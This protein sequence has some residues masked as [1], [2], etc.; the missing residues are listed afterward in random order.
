M[1]RLFGEDIEE[2]KIIEQNIKQ[3]LLFLN[4]T[5]GEYN[6]KFVKRKRKIDFYDLFFYM[7]H[8][9]SSI[10]ETHGSSNTNFCIENNIDV[11]ENAFINKLVKLDC[12]CIKNIN[13]RFINFYYTLF[14]ININDIVTAT[15][16]SNIKLLACTDKHFKLNSN[17]HYAN[18]SISCMYD[19]NNN[20][21]LSMNINNS[22][23]EID[24][25]L[26]QLQDNNI[27]KYKIT[28]VT[29]R[30]YDSDKLLKYYLE[31]NILFVS[32]ITKSNKYVNKLT[33][34]KSNEKFNVS[35]N[36]KIYN[37][38][39]IK[40]TNIEK[41]DIAETK[42]ELIIKMND[43][44]QKINLLKN[45]LINENNKYKKFHNENK[46]TNKE[47]RNIK[48]N[49][50]HINS[51]DKSKID[52]LSKKIKKTRISKNNCDDNIKKIKKDIDKFTKDKNLIKQKI[53]KLETYEHSDFYI[54]TNRNECSIEKLKKIYKQRWTVE[55]SFR[56]DKTVLNLNQMNNKNINLINQNVYIIQFI[57]IMNAFINKL[58][59]KKTK[60]D[61]YLNKTVIFKSLH[62]KI[63]S[64][65]KI[66]LR[67]KK[68]KS[69]NVAS[70]DINSIQKKKKHITNYEKLIHAL[71]IILKRQIKI[72]NDR[73]N[74]RIK[75][76]ISNNKFNN[77]KTIS[78]G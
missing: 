68:Y 73:I 65:I 56:H 10:N 31:N 13:D 15:D 60:K 7:L 25:L 6:R 23:N 3:L 54:L 21:P 22:F 11:S 2:N 63:F 9:N 49:K 26:N 52:V 29:D 19:V 59:E 75:K 78:N 43:I 39:I 48:A 72:I 51:N 24:N 46:L 38:Q 30:G 12:N 32:R 61:H 42:D 20:L 41:P 16:G 55:T 77:R 14:K 35:F 64:L 70:N 47:L 76:R 17:E 33:D 5:L 71:I 44:T 1:N 62:D 40:Y 28:N 50:L 8:Y 37:L 69:E 57:C 53:D 66:V 45:D 58:L 4:D 34:N 18:A 27:K 36:N 67:E 74:P